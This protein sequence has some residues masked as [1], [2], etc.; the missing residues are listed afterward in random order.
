V[1]SNGEVLSLPNGIQLEM[2]DVSPRRVRTVRVRPAPGA[3]VE[4]P[5]A[6]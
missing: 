4:A 1:P 6:S 2:I 3:N 5:S